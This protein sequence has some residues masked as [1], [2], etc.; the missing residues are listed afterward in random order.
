MDGSLTAPLKGTQAPRPAMEK[1]LLSILIP[2]RNETR[3]LARC[4]DSVL[5]SDYPAERMEVLAIDGRSTDGTRELISL[6]CATDSRVRLIDNPEQITPCA[7]NR[8]IAAARGSVI[9]RLDAHAAIAIDYWSQCVHHLLVSGAENV[10]GSM[11]TV[12]QEQG[13]W[14]QAI[15][16]ALSHGFGVGNSHFRTG[17]K[18]PKWVDT[19]FGGCWRREVFDRVGGFNPQLRRSQ[20]MEFS[21]RLRAA[22]GRTLLVPTAR[23]DYFARTRMR[24]FCRHNFVNGEWAILPFVYSSVIPV[25]WRHLVPGVFALSLLAACS[26][27]PWSTWPLGLVGAPYVLGNM[28]ASLQAACRREPTWGLSSLALPIVFLALHLCYGLGSVWGAVLA[29]GVVR[30]RQLDRSEENSCIPEQH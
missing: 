26:A 6:Y 19:V 16:T 21:L 3:F 20:D 24:D 28:A 12:A 15:V 18:E 27:L 9:A 14:A 10:G 22:G 30:G 13:V 17:V 8:G 7:L 2:C 23:C 25:S 29:A 5:A 4:L 11:R 1:P